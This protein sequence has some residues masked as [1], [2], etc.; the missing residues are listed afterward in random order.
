[1]SWMEGPSML[2]E[3]SSPSLPFSRLNTWSLGSAPADRPRPQMSP[4]PLPSHQQQVHLAVRRITTEYDYASPRKHQR[5]LGPPPPPV[6]PTSFIFDF[7]SYN[8]TTLSQSA[9][10]SPITLDSAYTPPLPFSHLSESLSS[11]SAHSS[12]ESTTSWTSSSSSTSSSSLAVLELATKRSTFPFQSSASSAESETTADVPS[13]SKQSTLA[14]RP[15]AG[16]AKLLTRDGA[17]RTCGTCIAVFLLRGIDWSRA[18]FTPKIE[19][20]CVACS[21]DEEVDV[22]PESRREVGESSY[23]TTISAA[24]DRLNFSEGVPEDEEAPL[25]PAPP[26]RTGRPPKKACDDLACG[27]GISLPVHNSDFPSLR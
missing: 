24:I 1:M 20:E 13:R 7:E 25:R 8:R 10:P 5:L 2:F 23:A 16:S 17:C 21:N 22:E 11:H 3:V 19:L 26:P 18:S 15:L 6:G 14:R 27:F 4:S 9:A 12:P